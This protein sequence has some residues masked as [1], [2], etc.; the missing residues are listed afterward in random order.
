MI[1]IH[2]VYAPNVKNTHQEVLFCHMKNRKKNR[3]RVLVKTKTK[4]KCVLVRTAVGGTSIIVRGIY[5]I[6]GIT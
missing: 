5:N 4:K 1:R 2:I 6:N 3:Y